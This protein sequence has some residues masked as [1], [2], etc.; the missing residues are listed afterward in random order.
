MASYPPTMNTDQGY[1]DF[2]LLIC[3]NARDNG[4]ADC[5]SKGSL[6]MLEEL[7]KWAKEQKFQKK[8]RIQKAGCLDRCA[9]G[10][11]C[12]AYPKG[13]WIVNATTNDIEA[14]KKFIAE[15]AR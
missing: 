13:E 2:H 4:K 7:K 3:T 5:A 15:R 12:V 1:Y 11:A 9:E 6:Q 8:I 10:I 14:M